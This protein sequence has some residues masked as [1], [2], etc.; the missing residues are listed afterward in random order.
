MS[1]K[2]KITEESGIKTSDKG[3]FGVVADGIKKISFSKKGKNNVIAHVTMMN[4]P[5][6]AA[7]RDASYEI[8]LM[9]LHDKIESTSSG[10]LL[11]AYTDALKL[12]NISEKAHKEMIN[13][14]TKAGR[15][16]SIDAHGVYLRLLSDMITAALFVLSSSSIICADE[17]TVVYLLGNSQSDE[18]K[19][20]L[21]L[22]S[23]C[24]YDLRKSIADLYTK[25]ENTVEKEKEKMKKN[26]TGDGKERYSIAFKEFLKK[27][28]SC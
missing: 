26:F 10:E 20:M 9:I 11:V 3:M 1:D 22:F 15:R 5:P 19:E 7:K 2:Y 14:M 4:I 23:K 18:A 25:A 16:N 28:E 17:Q 21:S 13:A 8:A 6:L 27:F 12:L 24:E